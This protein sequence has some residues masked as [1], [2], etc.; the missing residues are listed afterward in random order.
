MSGIEYIGYLE[1]IFLRF[2]QNQSFVF[3][4]YTYGQTGTANMP[5][6]TAGLTA[7]WNGRVL[8]V[9]KSMRRKSDAKKEAAR[10]ICEM[11][12]DHHLDISQPDVVQPSLQV[13]SVAWYIFVA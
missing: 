12:A 10:A 5:T 1:Q 8:S 11:I 7:T 2:R 6:H 4:R 9:T 13:S 3:P